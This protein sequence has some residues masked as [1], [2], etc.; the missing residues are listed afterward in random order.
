MFKN[1]NQRLQECCLYLTETQRKLSP[2]EES[3][4][5]KNKEKKSAFSTYVFL[6]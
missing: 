2:P 6:S 3:T 1:D 4:Y 5:E